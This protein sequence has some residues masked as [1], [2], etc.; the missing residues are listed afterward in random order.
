M[1]RR[2]LILLL[3]TLLMAGFLL[4]SAA[5]A[6]PCTEGEGFGAKAPPPRLEFLADRLPETGRPVTERSKIEATELAEKWQDWSDDY[7]THIQ[8]C[9]AA[10]SAAQEAV[11]LNPV[12][13]VQD[14]L[15]PV[16]ST[17]VDW[18]AIAACE[19]GGD[20]AIN[21]G[22]GYTGG[23]QFLTSTWL[24]Y[25]G[26]QYAPEAYLATREQQIAVASQM[27]LSHWPIC[28]AYG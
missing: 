20:W 14:N 6:A 3:P 9:E 12:P 19:S 1:F 22:N 4:P 18:D 5:Q 27:S 8:T 17:S 7:D 24:A 26:G 15:N 11:S 23:L 28:G 21:T 25:G 2:A 13:E 16:V 10:E